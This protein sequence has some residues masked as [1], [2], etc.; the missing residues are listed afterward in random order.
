M[1]RILFGAL[2]LLLFAMQNTCRGQSL[3]EGIK[4]L[5]NHSYEKAEVALKKI[6][7]EGKSPVAAYYLG[8][9]ELERDNDAGAKEYFLSVIQLDKDNPLGYVGL[10]KYF[11][12][13]SKSD[14]ADFYFDKAIKISKNKNSEVLCDIAEYCIAAKVKSANAK[15]YVEQ[16]IKLQPNNARGYLLNGDWYLQFNNDG[17][18]AIQQYEIAVEKE[19]KSPDAYNRIGY[20]YRGVQNLEASRE[21]YKK[22][23]LADSLFAPSYRNMADL[24]YNFGKYKEAKLFYDKYLNLSEATPITIMKYAFTLFSSK[25]Y[26]DALEALNNIEQPDTGNLQY[27]RLSGYIYFETADYDSSVKTLRKL[28]KNSPALKVRSSDYEYLGKS[29]QKLDEDSLALKNFNKAL[30][31]DPQK[32]YLHKSIGDIYYQKKDYPEAI[33]E[34]KKLVD[35]VEKKSAADIYLLGKAYYYN[36]ELNVADS[37]FTLVSNLSPSYAFVYM[38]RARCNNENADS[39]HVNAKAFYEK[40]ISLLDTSDENMHAYYKEACF[41][42]AYY[43]V[44]EGD[45]ETARQYYNNVLALEPGNANAK[46]YLRELKK[47]FSKN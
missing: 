32:I 25:D 16:A 20:I 26:A 14:S 38:Y 29:L 2:M 8:N 5:K 43:A 13:F 15:I 47:E 12:D 45:D 17:S 22:A 6:N 21:Y 35:S 40:F 9:L 1:K 34:Y 11:I 27:L 3:D 36:K 24:L 23:I 19:P 37:I 4:L 39:N 46:K 42:L 7:S 33:E 10:G 18:K 44:L 30:L 31:V 41:N 28:I